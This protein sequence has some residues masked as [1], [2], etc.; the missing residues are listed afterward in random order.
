MAPF[1]VPGGELPRDP[2]GLL[3]AS[4][5]VFAWVEDCR[6]ESGLETEDPPDIGESEKEKAAAVRDAADRLTKA[7]AARVD[8]KS[9]R[10]RV[11]EV[12][13][14]SFVDL[15]DLLQAL[16]RTA[17][18][19]DAASYL[20]ASRQEKGLTVGVVKRRRAA[21]AAHAGKDEKSSPSKPSR[22]RDDDIEIWE[23]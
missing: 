9:R 6:L 3:A 19:R 11:L 23:L 16:Y 20:R 1:S 21:H 4:E 10:E 8:A 22:S 12:F 18:L 13:N 14:G 15:V 17:G 5:A 2:A 7:E